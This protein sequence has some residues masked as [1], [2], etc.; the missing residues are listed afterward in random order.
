[1]KYTVRF[2]Q[3]HDYEIEAENVDEA[4][5]LA[6]EEFESDM[7]SPIANTVWDE[8]TVEN[9]DGEELCSGYMSKE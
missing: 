2:T 4:I 5:D 7:H 3:W 8:M 9:E 6:Q 1:M